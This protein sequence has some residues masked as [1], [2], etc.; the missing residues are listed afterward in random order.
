MKLLFFLVCNSDLLNND[1]SNL[2]K[3]ETEQFL[4]IFNI[5]T[6]KCSTNIQNLP[7]DDS[8][9]CISLDHDSSL[10]KKKRKQTPIK[11]IVLTSIPIT[12]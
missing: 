12:D 5:P 3:S 11:C 9:T 6:C 2:T 7:V 8:I 4:T 1:Q 10:D